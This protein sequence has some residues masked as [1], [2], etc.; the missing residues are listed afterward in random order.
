MSGVLWI[1]HPDDPQIY[2]SSDGQVWRKINDTHPERRQWSRRKMDVDK[3]GYHR[4]RIAGVSEYVHRLVYRLFVGPLVKGQVIRHL[5]GD[6]T[7]NNVANLAQGTQRDNMA[8]KQNHGT[9]QKGENHPRAQNTNEV[10][11]EVKARVVAAPRTPKGWLKR[12]EAARIA[13]ELGV[14]VN[15]VKECA[16][17]RPYFEG[18]PS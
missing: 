10:V 1:R 15:T 12:G 8:D 13:E 18:I 7:N 17:T 2:V 4:Y 14:S 3:D 16:R 9:A 11:D 6:P 5:D